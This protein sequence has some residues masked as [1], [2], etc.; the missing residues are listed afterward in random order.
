MSDPEQEFRPKRKNKFESDYKMFGVMRR[1][2]RQGAASPVDKGTPEVKKKKK[3]KPYIFERRYIGVDK[4]WFGEES[5]K[6]LVTRKFATKRGRD[7][8]FARMIKLQ[9]DSRFWSQFEFRIPEEKA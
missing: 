8:S 1:E 4:D 7:D 5:R 3:A 9:K 6:W 2:I